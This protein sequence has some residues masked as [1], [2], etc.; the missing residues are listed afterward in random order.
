MVKGRGLFIVLYGP[1]GVGKKSQA[2]IL[3]EKL[4]GVGGLCRRVRYPVYTAGESGKKLN[5][6]LHHKKDLLPEEEMQK[7][8]AKNRAE[9]ET[10][11]TSWLNSGVTVIGENYKGTGMVWGSVRGITPEKMEEI[12]KGSLDPDVSILIDGPIREMLPN[13][14]PYGDE[15]EWYKVRKIYQHM[16]DK[17]GWVGVGGDAPVLVVANRIWAV[18]RP[19][20]GMR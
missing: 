7:L 20:G 5:T 18:V 1:E 16:A 17:Y 11:L 13:E 8:F 3:E 6:L 10:T 14:H 4:R 15:E 2:G 9:F 12:N 19:V